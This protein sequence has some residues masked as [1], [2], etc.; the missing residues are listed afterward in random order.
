MSHTFVIQTAQMME[1]R[2][3]DQ[4]RR[5]KVDAGLYAMGGEPTAQAWREWDDR[6]PLPW[7]ITHRLIGDHYGGERC[8]VD[9]GPGSG[10]TCLAAIG[11]F[12]DHICEIVLVDVSPEMLSIAQAYLQRDTQTVITCI[13]AD[14][15]Q[16]VTALDAALKDFPQPRL[17]LCLG[18]TVGD[19]NQGYA[20]PTLR[21]FLRESDHLL[22]DFGLYPKEHSEDFWKK[23]ANIYAEGAYYFGLHSLAACGAEPDYQHT[24]TSVEGDDDDPTVQVIRVFYRS[25]QETVLTV[26]KDQVVFKEGE[27]VQIHESRR[28][29]V[30][31]VERHL[32]KYG[33][34]VVSSQHFETRGM[35]LCCRV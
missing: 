3:V 18:R 28:F 30:D 34:G 15:L 33:L 12:L 2:M 35:F 20:L 31:Q 27:H 5:R 19:F 22:V 17:F 29:L 4:L 32:N 21:S 14:F 16:D 10:R 26:G 13:I 8:V 23:L 6:Y 7:D 25:P 11:S 24:F 9:L 1:R